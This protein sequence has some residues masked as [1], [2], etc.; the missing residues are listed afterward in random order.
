MTSAKRGDRRPLE[1]VRVVVTRPERANGPLTRELEKRGATVLRWPAV[2]FAPPEDVGRLQAAVKRLSSYDGVVFTSRRAVAAVCTRTEPPAA[3]PWVAAV[4]EATRAAL[5]EAGWRVDRMPA[6][7]SSAELAR[8]L[9]DLVNPASKVLFPASSIARET[10][11]RALRQLGAQVD[12]VT[13]Y[14]TVTNDSLAVEECR[15]ELGSGG[16]VVLTFASPSA[17]RGLCT[18]FGPRFWS[19]LLSRWPS[20]VIGTTTADALRRAGGEPMA[21]AAPS[22]MA[23]LAAAAERSVRARKDA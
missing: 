8:A 19:D 9:A 22:T 3:R 5:E 2:Y 18:R 7:S 4:G 20:V 16:P 6:K 15:A 13:A 14:R 21:I 23:G 12:Q 11:P 10:L 17:V 1:G